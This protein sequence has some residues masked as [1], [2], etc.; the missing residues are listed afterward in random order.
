M[1]KGKSWMKAELDATRAR[2]AAMVASKHNHRATTTD[3]THEPLAIAQHENS[4]YRGV[5]TMHVDRLAAIE[6]ERDA[7]L[8]SAAARS[9]EL[10]AEKHTTAT[11]TITSIES[12]GGSSIDAAAVKKASPAEQVS[13]SQSPR[14]S[15]ASSV[16]NEEMAP[17][18]KAWSGWAVKNPPPMVDLKAEME[19]EAK[20]AAT[21]VKAVT[22]DPSSR[23]EDGSEGKKKEGKR[24]KKEKKDK[25]GGDGKGAR[26]VPQPQRGKNAQG[27]NAAPRPP[28]PPTSQ[29]ACTENISSNGSWTSWVALTLSRPTR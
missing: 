1:P 28:P 6:T 29:A 12:V 2:N 16:E 13:R 21:K 25:D 14:K 23:A 11:V 22:I 17:L 5:V 8:S 19:E 24:E 26:G 7:A 10:D 15:P 20:K 18:K 3:P 4:K 27:A 9:A